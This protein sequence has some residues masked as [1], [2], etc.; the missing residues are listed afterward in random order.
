MSCRLAA[1]AFAVASS[2]LVAPPALAQSAPRVELTWMSIANWDMKVN[3]KRIM[4]DA[5]ITRLPQSSFMPPPG[6]PGDLYAYTKMPQAVDMDAIRKV[7]DA[8]LGGDKLDLLLVG[9]AH[10]DHSWDTPSWAKLTGTPCAAACRQA[11]MP[12]SMGAP[13]SLAHEGVSQL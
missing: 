8:E 3:D 4:M 10:W 12:P 11:D 9:H 6:I 2:A 13:V 5:Y 7:R 1:L